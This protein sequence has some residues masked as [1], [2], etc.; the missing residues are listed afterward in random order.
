MKKLFVLFSAIFL[1]TGTRAQGYD[2]KINFKGCTDTMLFLVKYQ[3]DQ[4]YIS[5]TAKNVKN[6]QIQFKG[7]KDLD[8]G[9]YTLVSQG[10]SIYFDFFINESAKF[11]INTDM[12]DIVGNLKSANSKENEL[13]F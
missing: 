2:I 9:V 10:K 1:V 3:F 8:K 4:Q 7:K 12:D 11:T 5:D 6:G 13:F